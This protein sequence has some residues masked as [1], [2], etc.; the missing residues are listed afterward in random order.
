MTEQ[1]K[2]NPFTVLVDTREQSAFKFQNIRCDQKEAVR[3]NGELKRPL[4]MIPIKHKG[5]KTGDYAIDG[6][7]TRCAV[8]R[9]SL[10]DLFHCVGSDRDR[11]ENQLRRLNE[12]EHPFVVV[13]AS[14]DRI[15]KGCPRSQ[16]KP[17]TVF[18][19][20]IAWQQGLEF[21]RIHWWFLHSKRAA[22]LATFRI[23]DRFWK[24]NR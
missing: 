21:E 24:K 7:E 12:L 5:L 19:S 18:R 8:E 17:K 23:L 2:P 1:F 10:E 6:L 9:K 16:L 20:V 4:L 13:E 22:E 14:W 11:F 3:I 15:F